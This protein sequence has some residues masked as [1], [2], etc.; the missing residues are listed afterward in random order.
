MEQVTLK[1]KKHRAFD[2]YEKKVN[3]MTKYQLLEHLFVGKPDI[4][5]L[6]YIIKKKMDVRIN[7]RRAKQIALGLQDRIRDEITDKQRDMIDSI[8]NL[9]EVFHEFTTIEIMA[10]YFNSLRLQSKEK[11]NQDDS[12]IKAF[13]EHI[14]NFD[15]SMKFLYNMKELIEK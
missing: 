5:R 8:F 13:E 12:I 3:R 1:L 7:E 9:K 11:L 4:T 10:I 15:K 14:E 6:I 2:Y